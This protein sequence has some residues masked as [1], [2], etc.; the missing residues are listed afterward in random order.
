MRKPY[1]LFLLAASLLGV[2]IATSSNVAKQAD[3]SAVTHVVVQDGFNEAVYKDSYNDD[4]WEVQGDHIRQSSTSESYLYNNGGFN[5][6]CDRLFFG[7]KEILHNIEYFQL[8]LRV[9]FDNGWI[10][11]KFVKE[12]MTAESVSTFSYNAP[13]M[14]YRDKVQTLDLGNGY[15]SSSGNGAFSNLMGVSHV[16]N[17]WFSMRVVPV[18]SSSAKVYFALAG[19][20]FDETKYWT[21]N[22]N[23]S[24]GMDFVNG[25]FGIQTEN[26]NRKMSIDNVKFKAGDLIV[27][28]EFNEYDPED[29]NNVFANI[30][31]STYDP[32]GQSGDYYLAGNS[33]L[34]I[35]NGAVADERILSKKVISPDTSIA[36]E[37]EVINASFNA[38]FDSSA[39][40]SEKAGFIFGVDSLT[41]PLTSC[42]G[43]LELTK[44]TGTI[45]VFKDNAEV[46]SNT[47]N[48]SGLTS[49]DG[50]DIVVGVFKNG[51]V[52]VT[53]NGTQVLSVTGM[54]KYSGKVGFISLSAISH[55]VSID[56]AV[57]KNMS[58]FVPVTKSVTHNFSN[59]FFGNVGYEDFYLNCQNGS[60]K[61]ED[62]R[63]TLKGCSDEAFFGSAYQYDSFILDYKL[64]SIYIGTPGMDKK[65][66]T[67][68]G[69]WIGLDLSRKAKTVGQYGTYLMLNFPIVP[70]S[71]VE[72][73]Y[74]NPFTQSS[75]DLDTTEI[76]K[77][78]TLKGIPAS[79]LR[80]LQYDGV[81][82]NVEDIPESDFLC[83]RWVSDGSSIELYLKLNGEAEFTKYATYKN[84][85][86]NGYFTLC[87]TGFTFIQYD[88]FSMANTSPLYV[89]A[90]NEV[91]ETIIEETT[92]I[93]YDPGNVDVNLDEELRINE[94][95]ADSSKGCGGSIIATSAI[96]SITS[97]IGVGLVVLKKGRKHE[98]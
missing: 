58:Y 48:I 50:V 57:I 94:G 53:A 49:A 37:I 8:D 69:K 70:A 20:A 52:T 65:D 13:I 62:G 28:E 3:A 39:S 61:A 36:T 29:E 5:S 25:Q 54:E 44:S 81:S 68:E 74:V 21:V 71:G 93:H 63:L 40:V 2:A 98:E 97:L 78:R 66:H 47:A 32:N 30:H 14:L 83:I 22:A 41:S 9:T 19:Q 4:K 86:L 88:D 72:E 64:C 92:V 73:V 51:K 76:V 34:N 79:Y 91:P 87:C 31:S 85:E 96:I 11:I 45:R 38:K 60:M 90:D 12:Q 10:G 35:N 7:T 67:E 16:E 75:S 46:A 95:Q 26:Q 77:N 43:Y 42:G 56:D 89:C 23:A 82:K 55:T 24:A 33:T 18:S 6:F 59:N 27:D 1:P 80:N 15:Y 84:L 17:T